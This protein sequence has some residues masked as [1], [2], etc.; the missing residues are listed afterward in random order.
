VWLLACGIAYA[1]AYV[2]ANDVVA[3]WIYQGYSRMDQAVSELSALSAPPR[4]FLLAMLPVFSVLMVAFGIGVWRSAAGGRALRVAGAALVAFGVTGVLWLPF[5]MSARDHIARA[6]GAMSTNDVGHLV[7]SGVTAVL[8]VTMCVAGALHFGRAFR[9]YSAVT[10]TL[11]LVFSGVLTGLLSVKLTTGEPT[12]LLGLFERIGIGAWLLW[13]TVLALVLM[14]EPT[15]GARDA[16]SST[17]W[18]GR[19]RP[20]TPPVHPDQVAD[21]R[22]NA[23]ILPREGRE[24]GVSDRGTRTARRVAVLVIGVC[25]AVGGCASSGSEGGGGADGGGDGGGNGGGSS[26]VCDALARF[27]NAFESAVDAVASGDTNATMAAAATLKQEAVS[28]MD[29]LQSQDAD[30]EPLS[31]AVRQLTDTVARLPQDASA[32]RSEAAL[33]PR[34]E[35]VGDAIDETASGLGC[36]SG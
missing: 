17:A 20:V 34:I 30:V 29:A 13:L 31:T 1:A 22:Q 10:V 18:P 28:L 5:P 11:V 3:A 24:R 33:E 23:W 14:R 32:E 4:A 7:L 27:D 16:R 15:V 9:V 26:N 19:G 25:L 6:S 2:V 8:I 12:P 35:A 36:P 21:R